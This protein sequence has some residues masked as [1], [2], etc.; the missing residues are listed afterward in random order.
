MD[1]SILRINGGHMN[2]NIPKAKPLHGR[3]FPTKERVKKSTIEVFKT[4]GSKHE[5]VKEKDPL[6]I[7]KLLSNHIIDEWQHAYG[8]QIITLHIIANAK[9]AGTSKMDDMPRIPASAEAITLDRITATD[10]YNMTMKLMCGQMPAYW[11]VIAK[12][13]FDELHMDPALK[14]AGFRTHRN[15]PQ[16][17]QDAFDLLGDCLQEM[18]ARMDYLQKTFASGGILC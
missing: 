8:M 2:D 13:C 16:I 1:V 4:W 17:V 14:K 10:R 7:D 5:T 9:L 15:Q 3:N 12:L 18:R 11:E 6:R